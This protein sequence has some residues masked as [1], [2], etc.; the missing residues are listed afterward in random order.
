MAESR[1]AIAAT[2]AASNREANEAA[3]TDLH[4]RLTRLEIDVSIFKS[5][6]CAAAPSTDTP[7]VNAIWISPVN[8]LATRLDP[9]RIKTS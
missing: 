4:E 2:D 8:K 7:E 1:S 5:T 9:P 3:I 6:P